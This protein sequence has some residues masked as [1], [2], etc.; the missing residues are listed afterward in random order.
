VTAT[1]RQ[2]P[3]ARTVF[4][5]TQLEEHRLL[6]FIQ[7]HRAPAHG[8]ALAVIT[9]MRSAA[10]S[11]LVG[12]LA[13]VVADRAYAQGPGF[14]S[15]V[16]IV[17]PAVTVTNA[18]GQF[19]SGLTARDLVVYDD[20]VEQP[21]VL[22]GSEEVPLDL[23]FVL[24][25]SGST[26]SDLPLVK[27]AA[28]ALVSLLRAGDRTAVFEVKTTVRVAARLT[29]DLNAV[30]LAI[31]RLYASG[32]SSFY[33]GVNAA[34]RE[35]ERERSTSR[36]MRRQ[37]LVLLSDGFDNSSEVRFRDVA[38]LARRVDVTI[39]S[40]AL[41]SDQPS[42]RSLSGFEPEEVGTYDTALNWLARETGGLAFFPPRADALEA[43]LASIGRELVSQYAVGYVA[44]DAGPQG[45]FRHLSVRMVP[46]ADGTVRTRSGYLR[47]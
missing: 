8:T 25:T 34:L 2:L 5:S 6:P 4:K 35:F 41:R 42:S 36:E 37:A 19:V 23:A 14:R 11:L 9:A 17:A 27:K 33:D 26:R 1:E 22:F 46:P 28:L 3:P 47:K 15:G 29:A 45:A 13:L 7:H 12:A 24:D 31:D 10:L 32:S 43:I 20:G 30:A 21:I 44:P 39:Y 40:V 16:D 38:R 18:A